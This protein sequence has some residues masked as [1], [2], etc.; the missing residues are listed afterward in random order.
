MNLSR[1]SNALLSPDGQIGTPAAGTGGVSV[2]GGAPSGNT[3]PNTGAGSGTPQFSP[4][5]YA[6]FQSWKKS[7]STQEQPKGEAPVNADEITKRAL[8]ELRKETARERHVSDYKSFE[9]KVAAKAKELADGDDVLANFLTDHLYRQLETSRSPY[10][11]GHPL[12]GEA[13]GIPDDAA[14]SKFL[15]EKKLADQIKTWRGGLVSKVGRQAIAGK[16]A[17]PNTGNASKAGPESPESKREALR[18]K[19]SEKLESV[20]ITD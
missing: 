13:L 12:A 2:G 14:L 20:G 15:E 9:Q 8:A 18:A 5:E 3:A 16:A 6:E 4:D 7:R 11:D 1:L 17:A 10:P 19:W